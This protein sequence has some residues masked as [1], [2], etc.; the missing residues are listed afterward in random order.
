MEDLNF[1]SLDTQI[2]VVRKRLLLLAEERRHFEAN[3]QEYE[4]RLRTLE[5]EL[6]G[7]RESGER[8]AELERENEQYQKSQE[9]IRRQVTRMLERIR[10]FER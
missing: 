6:I 5:K 2:G 10:S 4:E 7:L 9:L 3:R 1:R 8:F